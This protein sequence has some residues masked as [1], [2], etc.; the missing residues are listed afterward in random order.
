MI[1]TLP[2]LR[3]LAI[4]VFLVS[5]AACADDP[6]FT[7]APGDHVVL[8]G[9]S[10]P[11]R[12]QHDGW[13]ETYLQIELPDHEL[14]LRNQGFTGD[15][16]DHRPRSEGFPSPDDYLGLSQAD[17]IFAMFGFNES[18]DGEPAAFGAALA[19]WVDHT[20]AQN[21]SGE[22]PPRIVLFSPI[23][24]EDLGRPN[25]PDGSEN[26]ARLSAYAD[27]MARVAAEKGVFYVD[28]FGPSQA[29]YAEADDPLTINGVH[30]TSEGNRRLAGL[31]LESVIG[32][33]PS[34]DAERVAAVREAV[35]DK[36]WHWHNRYRATDGNDVW[37][38]RSTLAFTDG[39]T[40]YD[41]LQNELA[42]LDY[43]TT[44]RDP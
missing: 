39:Q 33:S 11:D 35:L 24:H 31:I 44:N 5:T 43:L 17:V 20:R 26:N 2:R 18:F 9:N 36:N 23:A 1:P 4:P 25:L 21:Y 3:R 32:R 13:L 40:N 15:R 42:Q 19:D 30:L 14:V 28:L 29:L 12:M 8:I 16:I 38:N 6:P 7:L 27:A 34:R 10:L 41:V 22:G 37:G